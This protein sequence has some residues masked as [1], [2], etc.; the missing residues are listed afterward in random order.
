TSV[1]TGSSAFADDDIRGLRQAGGNLLDLF[2][3]REAGRFGGRLKRARGARIPVTVL[4]GFL[5][6]GEETVLRRLLATAEGRGTAVIINEFGSVGIDDALVRGAADKVTLLG[7]GCLCC[8]TRSDLEIALRNL[9]AERERGAV[10][11]FQRIVIET[12]GIADPGPILQTFVTDR[13]LG[14]EFHVEVVVAVVDAV[15][16]LAT[17]QR[18]AE[19]RKQVILADRLVI[20]KTDLAA[21]Q[22]VERLTARLR[23]LNPRADSSSAIDGELEPHCLTEA[24]ADSV[25]I[26]K[27]AARSGFVAEAEHSDGVVSFVLTDDVPVPWDVFVRTLETL[28]ALR[29]ADLLRVKGF[30]NVVGCRGPVLIQAVQHL[31]HPLDAIAPWPSGDRRRRLEFITVN[32]REAELRAL[33][34]A[35]Q[36]LAANVPD[37]ER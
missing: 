5:G 12:S 15:N 35:V 2:P 3:S 14:G 11:Q 17:L 1:I 36:A 29:G 21:A 13:A 28:I 6:A 34:E 23:A 9:V 37:A 8:N 27:A 33:L 26:S 10:P 32:I 22:T 18:A 7:N 4:T 19:A 31:A 30:L 25:L 16:G 20:T 24:G